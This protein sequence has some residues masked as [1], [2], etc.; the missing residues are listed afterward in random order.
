[1]R[2]GWTIWNIVSLRPH[3]PLL[4][5]LALVIAPFGRMS[6][7]EAKA[8]AHDMSSTVTSH[9]AG[10]PMPDGD[11]DGRVAIDCMIACTAMAPAAMPFLAPQLAIEAAPLALLSFFTAGIRPEADPPPPRFS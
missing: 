10:R 8:M 7:A 11:K 4:I 5:L 6:M 3:L 2:G 1:V 9:C